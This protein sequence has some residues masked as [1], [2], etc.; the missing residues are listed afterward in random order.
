MEKFLK[1]FFSVYFGLNVIA[2]YVDMKNHP[3]YFLI[4]WIT[5]SYILYEELLHWKRV[6]I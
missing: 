6:S 5:Y 4:A 1:L 3:Y 2:F